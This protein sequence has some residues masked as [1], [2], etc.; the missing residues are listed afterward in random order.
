MRYF[1]IIICCIITS[2]CGYFKHDKTASDPLNRTQL[3]RLHD[4]AGLYQAE[5]KKAEDVYGFVHLQSHCDGLLFASLYD[6]L[7]GTADVLKAAGEEPGRWYRRPDHAGCDN[8]ISRDMLIGLA[9][10]TWQSGAGRVAQ[11]VVDYAKAHD[12]KMGEG[13]VDVVTMSPELL[14]TFYRISRAF[15]G[16]DD[17]SLDT[18]GT[19]LQDDQQKNGLT[20]L[21]LPGGYLGH[22]LV[23]HELL[24]A[25]VY[26]GASDYQKQVFD[27]KVSDQPKN[28][29]F[30]A[31]AHLYGDGDQQ[32]VYEILDNTALFP[33]DRLPDS[34][35][36]CEDYLWQRDYDLARTDGKSPDWAP[37]A[38]PDGTPPFSGLDLRFALK[39]AENTLR[40]GG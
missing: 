10:W 2:S 40:N 21:P 32:L 9:W 11:D 39:I 24:R 28:A 3:E 20:A 5:G 23:L 30:Q 12:M 36:R 34:R 38:V 17:P 26:G 16:A 19:R 14:D 37:C 6:A 22:L 25:R 35:D 18:A 33:A 15:G 31:A 8:D 27:Q 1:Y 4:K 7:N 29:F 13:P